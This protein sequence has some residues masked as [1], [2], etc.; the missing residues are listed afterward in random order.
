MVL[1]GGEVMV[2]YGEQVM[3]L[4][5]GEVMHITCDYRQC[6]ATHIPL[7]LCLGVQ[8]TCFNHVT[9]FKSICSKHVF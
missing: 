8:P 3:L 5:G 4:D 2:L 6:P 1:F 9:H 7:S